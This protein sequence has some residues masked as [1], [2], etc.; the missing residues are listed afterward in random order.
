[1]KNLFI[2]LIATILVSCGKNQ[3]GI[4]LIP[5]KSGDKWG[6]IDKEGKYI[7]NAQF[8]EGHLFRDGLA[9]VK[10]N[11]KFG[12]IGEDGKY[13]INPVY[14]DAS[15]F[16]E[17]LACVIMENAKPQFIN[18]EGKIIFTVDA[19]I[20]GGFSEGLAPVKIKGKWGYI[21]NTGKIKINPA[22]E[23]A[24]EF[25]EGL[26]AVEKIDIKTKE[27][28]WGF[29]DRDG[30]IKI[31]F[32]FKADTINFSSPS[33]FSEGLAFV[34][35]DGKK[36]GCINKEGKYEINPQFEGGLNLNYEFTRRTYEFK[37]GIAAIKQGENW[38]YIDKTGKYIINPQFISAQD[39]TSDGIAAVQGSD[40]RYGFIDKEG[41]YII[42]PQFDDVKLGYAGDFAVV[43]SSDKYGIINDKGT[44]LVNPQFDGVW[45][46][47]GCWV[48]DK[49]SDFI[50]NESLANRFFENS[51]EGQIRNISSTSTV[52]DI[53][54]M[55]PNASTDDLKMYSLAIQKPDLTIDD[56][57]M[58]IS[59]QYYFSNSAFTNVPIYKT[60]Q[61]YSYWSGGYINDKEFDHYDKQYNNDATISAGSFSMG[62]LTSGDGKSAKLAEVFK[63]IA[64][65]KLK[66]QLTNHPETNNNDEKGLF[67]LR[68]GNLLMEIQYHSVKSDDGKTVTPI[69]SV[70][71]INKN[72][73]NSSFD[74]Q[75]K[76]FVESFI[77]ENKK[78]KS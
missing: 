34:S 59:I 60:V 46:C 19:D 48:G 25:S 31:D 41:K 64:I 13:V 43:E 72:Y 74:E 18:T 40:K 30:G 39:F 7:I 29:I 65:K 54:E 44:Y 66:M 50:D 21:D 67:V 26:A 17:G 9:L 27:K 38:G 62:L 73:S 51:N 20:C 11:D 1:M 52:K 22:Y 36:W 10:S 37:N 75:E 23:S 2:I 16:S 5:I 76:T 58:V 69:L 28:K 6:Y 47:T 49:K 42:N 12:Y 68:N 70:T 56:K 57:L 61:K 77:E 33:H 24:N 63:N 35:S 3:E 55:Y 71:Y 78:K 4:K 32:Q 53:I 8:E 14:K 45:I 15:S